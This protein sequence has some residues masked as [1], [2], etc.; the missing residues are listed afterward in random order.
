ME[1]KM[2]LKKIVELAEKH[3]FLVVN[4][5]NAQHSF[6]VSDFRTRTDAAIA[7]I[8]CA[9]FA[10]CTCSSCESGDNCEASNIYA[11]D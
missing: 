6:K 4:K 11:D 10:P 1:I 7:A 3:D 5:G 2:E 8:Q 9:N